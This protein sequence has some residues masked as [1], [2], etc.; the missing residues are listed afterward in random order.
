MMTSRNQCDPKLYPPL[1]PAL[2]CLLM[3]F[4]LALNCVQSNREALASRLAPSIL[5][6]HILANS[7]SVPDQNVKLEIRSFI[8]DYMQGQ[9]SSDA[10]K[11]ETVA[12]LQEHHTE[13]EAA[14]NS[15]LRQLGADYSATL[16]LTNCYFPTRVYDNLVI[17]C[18]YYDAARIILG[19]GTGH[20]WWCVLYP[21]FC[22]VDAACKVIPAESRTKLT[23]KLKQD[24][25]L[26]LENH[27]PAVTI[28]FLFLPS[29]SKSISA[30]FDAP[31]DSV[32]A[33]TPQRPGRQPPSRRSPS[34]ARD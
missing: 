20:N 5:R 34:P 19:N 3:A 33:I 25:A 17:P 12:Y 7:D 32:S 23:E 9:L 14:A 11:D 29:F 10:H 27:R 1:L 13:L 16:Q 28:R 31:D 18:G 15:R 4:L 30:V 6:F 2:A 26:A 21:R 22:F 24:D 8:L